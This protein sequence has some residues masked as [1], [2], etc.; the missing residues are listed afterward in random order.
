MELWFCNNS[1]NTEVF[2]KMP[3]QDRFTCGDYF[4]IVIRNRV[5]SLLGRDTSTLGDWEHASSIFVPYYTTLHYHHENINSVIRKF[6]QQ[7]Q[8]AS[9]SQWNIFNV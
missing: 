3:G 9:F 7:I 2:S 8:D 5:Y 1:L 4:H 6:L